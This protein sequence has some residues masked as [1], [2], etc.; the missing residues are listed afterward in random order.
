M[1]EAARS[2]LLVVEDDDLIL[3]LIVTRLQIAGF[4]AFYARNGLEGLERLKEVAPHGLILDINMPG[5]DGFGVLERMKRDGLH[6]RV[7][8][9][10]LTAR[11]Q[12]DDVKRAISLG[13]QD[14]LAK[15]F[16]DDQLIARTRRL[17]R[18]SRSQWVRVDPDPGA[19]RG[20]AGAP[21]RPTAHLE[22]EEDAV[23]I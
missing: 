4:Q 11:N 21:D 7:R 5:L 15:P 1:L 16:N 6:Q 18:P 12:P 22:T 19:E 3:E 2:R 10:V 13:A 14:F 17:V 9:M 23:M 20:L 8:T